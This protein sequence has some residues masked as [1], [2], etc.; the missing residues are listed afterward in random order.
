M[1]ALRSSDLGTL[2]GRNGWRLIRQFAGKVNLFLLRRNMKDL[3]R[4]IVNPVA[5]RVFL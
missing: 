5:G 2:C 1:A 3:T 4:Q